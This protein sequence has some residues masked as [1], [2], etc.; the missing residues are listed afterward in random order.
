MHNTHGTDETD[1][2]D[3]YRDDT[4]LAGIAVGLPRVDG[5]ET[6]GIVRG[7]HDVQLDEETLATRVL[8]DLE[9]TDHVV[10]TAADRIEV[11]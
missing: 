2:T 1:S 7:T 4:G 5:T 9:E 3:G 10:D 11:I 8:V 6:P